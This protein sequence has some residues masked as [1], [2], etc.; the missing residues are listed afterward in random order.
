MLKG[1]IAGFLG[2]LIALPGLDPDRRQL[3]LHLRNRRPQRRFKLFAGAGGALRRQPGAGRGGE[4]V[5]RP[6]GQ[7][8]TAGVRQDLKGMFMGLRDFSR[9]WI[10]MIR[11]SLIGTWIGILPGVGANIGSAFAYSIAKSLQPPARGIRQGRRG[12]R[13]RFGGGEQRHRGRGAGCLSSRSVSPAA[14]SMRS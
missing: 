14:S 8:A 1:L 4:G 3:P 13:D 12:G 9:H 5:L 6:G 2:M 11:A 7:R 10:G